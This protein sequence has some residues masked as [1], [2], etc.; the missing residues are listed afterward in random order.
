MKYKDTISPLVCNI[1]NKKSTART[2]K[3]KIQSRKKPRSN[4]L[5]WRNEIE[6]NNTLEDPK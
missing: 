3:T 2:N 5:D 1:E 4:L 6:E